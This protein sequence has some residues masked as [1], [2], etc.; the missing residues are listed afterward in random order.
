MQAWPAPGGSGRPGRP[1]PCPRSH[2]HAVVAVVG[3]GAD[4]DGAPRSS[5]RRPRAARTVRTR[6]AMRGTSWPSPRRRAKAPAVPLPVVR[7]AAVPRRPAGASATAAAAAAAT[8][9]GHQ[10]P[11]PE[12]RRGVPPAGVRTAAAA[13]LTGRADGG[14]ANHPPP[15]HTVAPSRAVCHAPRRHHAF[16]APPVTPLVASLVYFFFGPPPLRLRRCSVL[17]SVLRRPVGPTRRRWAAPVWASF[18]PPKPPLRRLR[19][20]RHRAAK[21]PSPPLLHLAAGH[22]GWRDG[23][24]LTG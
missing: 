10:S 8:A 23:C 16:R 24:A 14:T 13:V 2:T 3:G 9:N 4:D 21:R 7:G 5:H 1:R 18:V 22:C 19:R 12:T 6:L 20:Q 17:S 11:A 15:P